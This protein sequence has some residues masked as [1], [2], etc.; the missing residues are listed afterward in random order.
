MRRRI[1]EEGREAGLVLLE[2]VQKDI[3]LQSIEQRRA[4]PFALLVPGL[5]SHQ[6]SRKLS[7]GV[8]CEAMAE[9]EGAETHRFAKTRR[10]IGARVFFHLPRDKG[11]KCVQLGR[12]CRLSAAPWIGKKEAPGR[13]Q[14]AGIHAAEIA[15]PMAA[16]REIVPN[17]FVA[18]ARAIRQMKDMMLLEIETGVQRVPLNPRFEIWCL[19]LV[20]LRHKRS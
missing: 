20:G 7:R 14:A 9:H 5:F 15:N 3:Q 6:P 19:G 2:V 1:R 13:A 17:I 18:G 12:T 4:L 8:C 10:E 16:L 11:C